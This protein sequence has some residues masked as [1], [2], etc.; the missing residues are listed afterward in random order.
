MAPSSARSSHRSL[1]LAP[2]LRPQRPWMATKL[3]ED[4][5]APLANLFERGLCYG[6][7]DAV[8]AVR[9][10]IETVMTPGVAG[11]CIPPGATKDQ[12][13]DVVVS[14]LRDHPVDRHQDAFGLVIKALKAVWPCRQ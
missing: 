11:S 14:H 8:I 1:L 9:G 7:I 2:S 12:I 6:Y 3:Y 4:C 13:R 10:I 5:S